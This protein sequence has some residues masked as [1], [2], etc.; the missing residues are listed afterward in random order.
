[1]RYFRTADDALYEHIRLT[2]DEAWGLTPH[3]CT[4]YTA[5]ATA[6]RDSIGRIVIAV[7]AEFC[8]YSVVVDLLPDLLSSGAVEE[9]DRQTYMDCIPGPDGP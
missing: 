4:C 8:D 6:P 2:L 7:D 3:G 5:A 1:M 9:I